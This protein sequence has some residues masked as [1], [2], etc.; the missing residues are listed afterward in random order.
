MPRVIPTSILFQEPGRVV[1]TGVVGNRAR[2]CCI[3]G[4]VGGGESSCHRQ[5]YSSSKCTHPTNGDQTS[6]AASVVPTR[7]CTHS[8]FRPGHLVDHVTVHPLGVCP[9]R[10]GRS[11]THLSA[12]SLRRFVA[13]ATPSPRSSSPPSPSLSHSGCQ[14]PASRS[15]PPCRSRYPNY[16]SK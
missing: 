16:P 12:I 8:V 10:R 5:K 6:T 14:S 2:N 13:R 3:A 11:E 7:I 9:F 4:S 1:V 15:P